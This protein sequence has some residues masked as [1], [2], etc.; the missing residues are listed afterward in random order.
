[1]A[2]R[3][4]R[5]GGRRPGRVLD[6]HL[7]HPVGSDVLRPGRG[8][9]DDEGGRR[10][11]AVRHLR[12]RRR[13]PPAARA[14]G[15]QPRA[16][17]AG[18][19]RVDAG[20]GG[21]VLHPL[22][23]RRRRVQPPRPRAE[24]R[25]LPHG[26]PGDLR[27]RRPGPLPTPRARDVAHALAHRLGARPHLLHRPGRAAARRQ[28]GLQHALPRGRRRRPSAAA[29]S[30]SPGRTVAVAAACPACPTRSSASR[31]PFPTARGPSRSSTPSRRPTSRPRASG[32]A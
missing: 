31:R 6:R 28:P 27:R 15:V 21:A 24:G 11:R 9:H 18:D 23:E 20:A 2:A 13:P 17:L 29:R 5:H 19:G 4:R 26:L 14:S 32:S 8:A 10:V 3:D 7:P 25:R 1:M 16:R 22:R 12:L 30:T